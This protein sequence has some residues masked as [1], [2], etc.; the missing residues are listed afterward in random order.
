MR[1]KKALI[2]DIFR[3]VPTTTTR[4]AC[5]RSHDTTTQHRRRRRQSLCL[6][7]VRKV[8]FHFVEQCSAAH[9]Q[10]QIHLWQYIICI[11]QAIFQF[12]AS[13]GPSG[14]VAPRIRRWQSGNDVDDVDD[15][16]MTMTTTTPSLPLQPCACI[17]SAAR[18]QQ[19]IAWCINRLRIVASRGC[20]IQ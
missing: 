1:V 10:F 5:K 14:Y 12:R 2:I 3:I 17:Q 6:L 16:M 11:S 7:K 18:V 9:N 8:Q 4:S 20:G 19:C 15:D 13:R